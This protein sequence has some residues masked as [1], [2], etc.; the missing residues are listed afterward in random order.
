[1]FHAI[2]QEFPWDW[3]ELDQ[4]ACA[5]SLTAGIEAEEADH[6]RSKLLDRMAR[7]TRWWQVLVRNESY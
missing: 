2:D 5:R 1:M 7:E 3:N 4:G 6:K